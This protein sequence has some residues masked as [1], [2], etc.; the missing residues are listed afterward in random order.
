MRKSDR[1][2]LEERLAALSDV[3]RRRLYQQAS[4]KRKTESVRGGT[5]RVDATKQF[6]DGS[7]EDG[8]QVSKRRGGGAMTLDDWALKLLAD[9]QFD[10]REASTDAKAITRDGVVISIKAGV[11][12]LICED[13]RYRCLLRPE[14]AMAQ[15]SDLAIGDKVTF[16]QSQDGT[17]VVEETLPRKSTLSRPD[18]HDLR[19]ERVIAANIDVAVIVA[20]VGAPILNTNLVDRYLLA[21]ERGGIR[22]LLCVN[23]IDLLPDSREMDAKLAP[24]RQLGIEVL[25]CSAASGQGINS[26]VKSLAGSMAVFVGHSGVGKSSILNTIKPDLVLPVKDVHNKSKRGRHTTIKSNLY[27]L[28]E[29]ISVIDTPGVRSFGLWKMAPAE[30][31]W[32][33]SEFDEYAGGCKFSDCIHTHEPDCAVKEA[34]RQGKISR[35]R[36]ESYCRLME[37]LDS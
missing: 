36:Y 3:E 37:S 26:L 13:K 27:D 33:F 1:K 16:S 25:L 28:G 20:S 34:V 4:R 8:K 31:R 12:K 15:K 32:Y 10:A 29:G 22:P 21:I 18:P 6:R 35:S 14:L 19:V 9:G 7:I 17:C 24:Y 5:R 2:P 23:K 11:C 30:L